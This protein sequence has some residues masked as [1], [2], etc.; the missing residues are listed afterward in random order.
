MMTRIR[1]S[2]GKGRSVCPSKEQVTH[3]LAHKRETRRVVICGVSHSTSLGSAGVDFK[4]V[5]SQ[6]EIVKG[7]MDAPGSK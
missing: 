6:S 3:E 5:A 2:T 1:F 7:L 4:T